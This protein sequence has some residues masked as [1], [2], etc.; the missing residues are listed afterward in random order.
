M[1][2]KY[3]SP[4]PVTHLFDQLPTDMIYY[5]I[6]PYLD[7]DSR[8]TAN[9]LLPQQD[10]LRTPLRKGAVSE[11]QLMLGNARMKSLLRKQREATNKTTRARFTLKIWRMMPL[12]PALY[13]QNARF[14]EVSAAKAAEFSDPTSTVLD[15]VSPYMR[16]ELKR[17]CQDF[18]LSLETSKPYIC[19]LD[20]SFPE[21]NWSAVSSL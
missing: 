18:L 11:F 5:E 17:L 8:V 9:L 12:F 3:L 15:N 16:K 14:R 6:F 4:D 21:G 20:F 19:E 7:Y 13:Q 2:N 10:R 1:P